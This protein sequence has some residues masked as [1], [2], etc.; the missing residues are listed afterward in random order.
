MRLQLREK[1]TIE[2]RS[3][4]EQSVDLIYRIEHD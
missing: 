4:N 3:G 1:L 2:S